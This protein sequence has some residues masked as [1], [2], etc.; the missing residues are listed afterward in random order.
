[1]LAHHS[2]RTDGHRKTRLPAIPLHLECTAA[3]RRLR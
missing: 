1:V 3:G 2:K